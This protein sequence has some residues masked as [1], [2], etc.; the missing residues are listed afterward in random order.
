MLS[1]RLDLGAMGEVD[2]AVFLNER[3]DKPNHP[4]YRIVLSDRSNGR[5]AETGENK[6]DRPQPF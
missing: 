6:D 1:G 4:D 5:G 2:I 3:K